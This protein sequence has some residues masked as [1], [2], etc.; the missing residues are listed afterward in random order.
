MPCTP[1]CSSLEVIVKH[2]QDAENPLG[3]V[4][5]GNLLRQFR[6]DFVDFLGLFC[7]ES[8]FLGIAFPC[9]RGKEQLLYSKAALHRIGSNSRALG[10]K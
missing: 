6:G 5:I 7:E 1:Y 8:R 10:Y 4:G 3:G 9:L 2:R